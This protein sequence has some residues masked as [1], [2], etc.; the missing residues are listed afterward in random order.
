MKPIQDG[1]V[2]SLPARARLRSGPRTRRDLSR[3]ARATSRSTFPSTIRCTRCEVLIWHR[4]RQGNRRP[5]HGEPRLR[6]GPARPALSPDGKRAAGPVLKE[7]KLVEQREIHDDLIQRGLTIISDSYLDVF[8]EKCRAAGVTGERVLLDG[9]NW[10]QLVQDIEASGHD[11]VI[12]GALGLGAVEGSVLGSVC[13]RVARRI[14]RDLLVVKS[15][16]GN[17]S[18]AIVVALDGSAHS[19]AAPGGTSGRTLTS[20]SRPSR[21]S[22]PFHYVAFNSIAGARRKRQVFRFRNRRNCTRKSSIPAWQRSTSPISNWLARSRPMRASN[23]DD[24]ARRQPFQQILKYARRGLAARHGP[25]RY[26]FRTGHGSSSNNENVLRMSP[27]NAAGGRRF[28][29]AAGSDRRYEHAW[30]RNQR[31]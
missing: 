7:D 18:G 31:A 3:K 20:R 27:C 26:P 4:H 5:H 23:W 11:L 24:T 13:E 28:R 8:G 17:E 19:Y 2:A 30:S 16:D 29:A 1:N 22:I 10:Q 12:M 6:R 14:H 21:H 25:H 9:R 15:P